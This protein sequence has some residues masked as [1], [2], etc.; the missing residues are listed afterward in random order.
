MG[1]AGRPCH[2]AVGEQQIKAAYL[3]IGNSDIHNHK[4]LILSNIKRWCQHID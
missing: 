2:V 4:L 1:G 3:H